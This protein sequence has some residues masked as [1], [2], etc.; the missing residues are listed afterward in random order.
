MDQFDIKNHIFQEVPEMQD[1]SHTSCSDTCP[2][3]QMA[4]N[5]QNYLYFS[6]VN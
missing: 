2:D 6:L 1:I 4:K 5:S 3:S